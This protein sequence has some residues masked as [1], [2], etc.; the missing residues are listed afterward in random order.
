MKTAT[1]IFAVVTFLVAAVATV[2]GVNADRNPISNHAHTADHSYTFQTANNKVASK[3]KTHRALRVMDG[4]K[5]RPLDD[6]K[7]HGHRDHHEPKKDGKHSTRALMADE[8]DLIND[9]TIRSLGQISDHDDLSKQAPLQL[10]EDPHAHK[11]GKGR[12]L[13][14][15]DVGM[16][17]D[18]GVVVQEREANQCYSRCG[19]TQGYEI[20]VG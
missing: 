16:A 6:G 18:S 5:Q 14:L 11:K 12:T 2:P 9:L 1:S 10:K 15:A 8:L 7:H 20:D 3:T 17:G 13:V 4:P 19:W